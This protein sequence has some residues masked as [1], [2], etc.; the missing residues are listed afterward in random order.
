MAIQVAGPAMS[1]SSTVTA[2]A[3]FQHVTQN[4]QAITAGDGMYIYA[5]PEGL[6]LAISVPGLPNVGASAVGM[7]DPRA[8]YLREGGELRAVPRAFER[9]RPI[10]NVARPPSIA[11]GEHRAAVLGEYASIPGGA[12]SIDEINI[13]D[14]RV[15][16]GDGGTVAGRVRGHISFRAARDSLLTDPGTPFSPDTI[17]VVVDFFVELE[18]W[19]DGRAAVHFTDGPLSGLPPLVAVGSATDWTRDSG[20][21]RQL[22]IGLGGVPYDNGDILTLW[23][24]T[25]LTGRGSAA[26]EAMDPA[27]TI[28]PDAWP[29][30][31]VAGILAT[32]SGDEYAFR[33]VSGT[34]ELDEYEPS[35]AAQWGEVHGTLNVEL[36]VHTGSTHE[37]VTVAI[38]FHLPLGY[39]I[40]YCGQTCSGAARIHGGTGT[41]LRFWQS[42]T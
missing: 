10:L 7:W 3:G 40:N 19:P 36:S 42:M 34:I 25:R 27:L 26:I 4:L 20:P 18:N 38:S 5:E 9:Q 21:A 32:R 6:A 41:D 24:G 8:V 23:L 14:R 1:F 33:S 28:G 16:L 39:L 13:P 17:D 11:F 37:R 29:D 2:L 15:L 12:L 22:V 35:S 30:H 31:F